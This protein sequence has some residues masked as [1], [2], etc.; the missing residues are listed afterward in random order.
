MEI[1]VKIY[2]L[3][4]FFLSFEP[5]IAIELSQAIAKLYYGLID[6]I[7]MCG[8]KR[9]RDYIVEENFTKMK[10]FYLFITKIIASMVCLMIER[11]IITT[12]LM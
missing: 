7:K 11:F 4:I 6:A 2:Y 9:E 12:I 5:R 1:P 10:L 3:R 8:R